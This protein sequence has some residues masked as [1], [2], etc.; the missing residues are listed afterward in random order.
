MIARY[1]MT[2]AE[3]LVK[4]ADSESDLLRSA[5]DLANVLRERK[6]APHLEQTDEN[7]LESNKELAG[8][9]KCSYKEGCEQ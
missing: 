8:R 5:D 4:H 7:P 6:E 3:Y 2:D 9:L 1:G